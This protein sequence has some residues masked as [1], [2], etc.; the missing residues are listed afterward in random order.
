[1]RTKIVYQLDSNGVYLGPENSQESPLEHGKFLLPAGCVEVVP[2]E[3]D[4]TKQYAQWNGNEYEV[5]NIPVVEKVIEEVKEL[6][7]EELKLQADEALIQ[8]EMR[9]MA[10]E[11]LK[12]RGEL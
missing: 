1:M 6:T 11:R 8:A 3:F 4:N 9:D 2:P 5:K 7:E 10:I 12:E